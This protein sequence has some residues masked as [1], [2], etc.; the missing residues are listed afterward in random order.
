MASYEYTAYGEDGALATGQL[1]A[2]DRAEA[3]R[4]LDR[5]RLQPVALRES[6]AVAAPQVRGAV[7]TRS[8]GKNKGGGRLSQSQLSLFT[9]ELSELLKG[10]MQLDQALSAMERRRELSSLKEVAGAVRELI[11]EG[12]PLSTALQK[13]SPSFDELYRSLVAAGEASGAL[14]PVLERQAVHLSAMREL[15][16]RILVSL[17]YPAFLMVAAI[18]VAV[19][20]IV[21]LI[22]KLT[23]LL[24]STGGSLP[25]GAQMIL[26][27]ADFLK[28]TWPVWAGGAL[29]LGIGAWQWSLTSRVS[30]DAFRLKWPVF[31]AA[32]RARFHV[33]FL[34]TLQTLVGNGLPLNRALRLANAAVDNRHLR[35][36]VESLSRAVDEGMPLSRALERSGEFPPLLVDMVAVGEQTGDLSGALSRA[37]D[38]FRREM[39]RRIERLT[40]FVQPA[41]IL[42]MAAMTGVMAYIM[43]SAIFQTVSALGST[44]K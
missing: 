36:R 13:T 18:G 16:S 24:A 29:L 40:A 32:W 2:A 33:L 21:F 30:W 9:E 31:G 34:E 12:Q 43:V 27:G 1:E 22:P 41:V 5:R 23:D 44:G 6:G 39:D 19:L 35:N 10:G 11:R 14:G 38:R 3:C 15:R 25:V 37:S 4:L 42:L 8:N 28:R 26:D 17:V 20:F 7:P